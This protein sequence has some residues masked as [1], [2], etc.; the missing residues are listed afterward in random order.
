[1][2]L[3][4]NNTHCGIQ[5]FSSL[6]NE[7]EDKRVRNDCHTES[8]WSWSKK[9]PTHQQLIKI[10]LEQQSLI[11]KLISKRNHSEDALQAEKSKTMEGNFNKTS[12]GI[13]KY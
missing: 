10:I 12:A 5:Y 8:H 4:T 11:N 13:S 3:S 9:L 1:M 6:E 7:V 2:G